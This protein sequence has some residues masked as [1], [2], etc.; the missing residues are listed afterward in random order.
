[1]K[2]FFKEYAMELVVLA[3]LAAIFAAS[4][5]IAHYKR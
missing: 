5:V 3:M 2:K 4:M 1:M